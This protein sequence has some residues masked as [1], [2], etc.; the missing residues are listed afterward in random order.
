[1]KKKGFVIAMTMAAVLGAG[2]PA[3][4]ASALN[5][6][7]PYTE[8][9][10]PDTFYNGAMLELNPTGNVDTWI[11]TQLERMKR[12]FHIN[13][14]NLYGLESFSAKEK[15]FSELKR[16]GMQAVVR[17][18]G[19]SQDFAFQESDL[20]Y[21]VGVYDD[22]LDFVCQPAHRDQVAYFS[23]N[24][25]VDDGSVQQK[26]GG[27]NSELSKQRQVTYAQA[28]VKRMR[29]ETAARG[30]ADAKMFLS[31][32]Y[33]WDNSY[34]IPS[35]ASAGADGYFMN[36]Y[37]Y[38]KNDSYIPDETASDA[39]LINRARLSNALS[40]YRSQYPGKPLV[41]EFGFHTM[42]Y[43]GY[44]KPNQTAGLVM[45][46]EAKA[47]AIRATIEYYRSAAPEFRGALYFGYNLY[48][49]EGNPPAVMD[50][51]LDYPDDSPATTAGKTT[52]TARATAGTT[53]SADVSGGAPAGPAEPQG[54]AGSGTGDT[55]LQTGAG[56]SSA[57]SSQTGA[58]PSATSASPA[59][60]SGPEQKKGMSTATKA[61]LGVLGGLTAVLAGLL[62]AWFWMNRKKR[63]E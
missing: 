46:R 21:I 17:I 34:Q 18:E 45:N 56:T 23:L 20:P 41:V 11:T 44:V 15:L 57:A 61:A 22:L 8:Y 49:E 37:S 19:Y 63:P 35:Y 6:M 5:A 32:F 50:W 28:F 48:K 55:S 40:R 52:T 25:P 29:E 30:F 3:Y 7:A 24:M 43:N 54:T 36:N 51:T 47:R 53:A 14:V 62:G 1:M 4:P 12:E 26:L 2:V 31:I 59:D 58:F 39:D 9:V 16:L 33:G 13:T 27:I 42:E 60:G 38:P 10:S